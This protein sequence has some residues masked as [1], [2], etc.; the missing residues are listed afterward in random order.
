MWQKYHITM[1]YFIKV[2]MHTEHVSKMAMP[3]SKIS[4]DT[5]RKGP[6]DLIYSVI[7]HSSTFACDYFFV[8]L[9]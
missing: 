2:N 8:F 3:R 5:L 6:Y 9:V 4:S 1:Q 7:I